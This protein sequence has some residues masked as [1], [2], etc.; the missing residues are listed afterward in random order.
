MD[1]SLPAMPHTPKHVAR[2]MTGDGLS[3][4]AQLAPPG[5]GGGGVLAERANL[6]DHIYVR[7][8]AMIVD[9]TLLPGERIVPEQ[10]A[11]EM[12][13]SR[14]PM[15]SALKRLSQ[16]HLITWRSRRGVF[17]RRLS[18][19]ELAMIFEVREVLEGLAARRAATLI[20]PQQVERLRA[21]F[22]DIDTVDTPANRRAYL[23]QDYLFHS[24]I[25]EIAGSPPLTETTYSVNILVLAFGAG[26]IKSIEDGLTEHKA[27]LEALLRRD[28]EAAEAVMRAHVRRSAV[29]L[30]HE[31]DLIERASGAQPVPSHAGSDA[32]RR[33]SRSGQSGLTHTQG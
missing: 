16:E 32:K 18:K 19:R 7:I 11:R 23:S 8:K 21:L 9:G 3:G 29:W 2:E 1:A 31:A 30:H 27:I 13:V 5:A 4:V 12:G 15:L 25:L 22:D 10:L 24:G 33:A 17:V 14:T 20:T 6:D 28:P 26:L